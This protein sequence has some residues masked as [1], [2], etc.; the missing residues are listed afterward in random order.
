MLYINQ[1]N[2]TK[3]DNLCTN[4]IITEVHKKCRLKLA[5]FKWIRLFIYQIQPSAGLCHKWQFVLGNATY[6]HRSS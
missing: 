2:S 1:E 5:A 3:K 6:P 4:I